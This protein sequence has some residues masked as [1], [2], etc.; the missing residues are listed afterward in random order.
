MRSND[1]ASRG[2]LYARH[3]RQMLSL[4]GSRCRVLVALLLRCASRLLLEM[5]EEEIRRRRRERS[6]HWAAGD[7]AW[8]W[9]SA[10][11]WRVQSRGV[12][13]AEA[14]TR[15]GRGWRVCQKLQTPCTSTSGCVTA[16]SALT[17]PSEVRLHT[18]PNPP[19]ITHT[20]PLLHCPIPPPRGA[21]PRGLSTSSHTHAH[22]HPLLSHLIP[23][24][25]RSTKKKTAPPPGSVFSPRVI[26]IATA[27]PLPR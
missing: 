16:S 22:S 3:S 14:V 26:G 2:R 8:A 15:R 17:E 27:P 10:Y 1:H 12:G 6:S 24:K 7:V 19:Q 5:E 21:A 20:H 11:S 25:H 18:P 23:S 13:A 4:F 9:D